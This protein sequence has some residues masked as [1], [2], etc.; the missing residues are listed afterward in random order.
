MGG[1]PVLRPWTP[2]SNLVDMPEAPGTQLGLD[3][4]H[5]DA[6]QNVTLLG[7][8]RPCGTDRVNSSIALVSPPS[9]LQK[10]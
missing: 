4:G 2:D 10:C 3:H 1:A 5:F 6:P 7:D 9:A 8:G